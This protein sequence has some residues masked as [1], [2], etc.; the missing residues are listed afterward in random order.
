MRATRVTAI[1]VLLVSAGL[2]CFAAPVRAVGADYAVFFTNCDVVLATTDTLAVTNTQ[3]GASLKIVAIASS[4]GSSAPITATVER[5]AAVITTGTL[6]NF[7]TQAPV[8]LLQATG[9]L[10]KIATLGCAIGRI[11]ADRI[12]SVKMMA[13]ANA[14]ATSP[15]YA[16]TSIR[17]AGTPGDHMKIL[18][19]GAIL[20]D[21][22]TSQTLDSANVMTKKG[23]KPK[24]P[25]GNGNGHGKKAPWSAGYS[26]AGIGRVT[27]EA[28]AAWPAGEFRIVASRIGKLQANG[29]SIAPDLILARQ[30]LPL[31]MATPAKMNK[32]ATG[33]FVGYQPDPLRMR[34]VAPNIGS[35]KAAAGVHGVFMAGADDAGLPTYTGSIAS[36]SVKPG[37][38]TISGEAYVLANTI[39][40]K[41]DAGS[42]T[43]YTAAAPKP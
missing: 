19:Q 27:P 20:A 9:A 6:A 8:D 2:F 28:Q 34:V 3:P 23:T 14:L 30:D 18:L 1:S 42:M 40:F 39:R 37:G 36:I 11:E 7:S 41:P 21:L 26:L 22:V 24:N 38:A 15:T 33:G 35:V 32:V 17:S 43:V 4:S 29:A 10:V 5:F 16:I 13:S 12:G 31:L 25:G